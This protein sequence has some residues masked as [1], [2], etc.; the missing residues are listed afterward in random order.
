MKY[1]GID[2][3]MKKVGLAV[4]EGQVASPL[5]VVAISGLKD[6]VEKVAHEI[7][8]EEIQRVVIGIPEG[9]T[10]KMVKSFVVELKKKYQTEPVQII[11]TDETLTSKDAQ[12]LMITL[13]TSQKERKNED[14]Y[15]AMLILQQ[16]LDSLS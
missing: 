13:G 3:G 12:N 5:K 15:S 7:R 1:L 11:E 9:S 4:S 2:Y 14:A 6:G 8:R 16:F 10:G